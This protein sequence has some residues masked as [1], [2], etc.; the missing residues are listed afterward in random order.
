MQHGIPKLCHAHLALK[1][2]PLHERHPP[3]SPAILKFSPCFFG[4]RIRQPYHHIITGGL[5]TSAR[6]ITS[7]TRHK[8]LTPRKTAAGD[9]ERQ[10]IPYAHAQVVR[11]FPTGNPSQR[12]DT[13]RA[14]SPSSTGL[15][16]YP[17]LLVLPSAPA[18]GKP[19]KRLIFPVGGVPGM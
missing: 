12:D 8:Y 15:P 1:C 6:S 10:S 3:M 14:G 9:R 17:R 5:C 7:Q 18:T 11:A 19:I 4:R 16:S 2:S 13:R